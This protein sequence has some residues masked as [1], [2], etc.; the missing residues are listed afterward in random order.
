MD[1]I[2]RG[3]WSTR[4]SFSSIV[5]E[6]EGWCRGFRESDIDEEEWQGTTE[7]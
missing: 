6:T 5:S 2:I 3:D 4:D 7:A 1:T